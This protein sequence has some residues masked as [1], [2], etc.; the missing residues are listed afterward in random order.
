[1]NSCRGSLALVL[2]ALSAPAAA[3]A[4]KPASCPDLTGAERLVL[5]LGEGLDRS[6]ARLRLYER[7]GK[8][9]KA[10][11]RAKPA[12]LG[13]DGM[14]WAWNAAAY[15]GG[16]SLK[17]EG[18]RRTP[19]GFFPI[20]QPF[21]FSSGPAGYVRLAP[22]ESYCVDDPASAHYNTVLRKAAAGGASGEDMGTIALYRQGLFVD[23]PTNAR[24]KGGSCIFLHTWRTRTS[25]TAGCVALAE[26]DVRQ[27]QQWT[28]GRKALIAILP[29]SAWKTLSR[30][31][32]GI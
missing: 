11:G 19:A 24:A 23:Y 16:S 20:G 26:K 17:A 5:V 9:W 13:I 27:V 22:G 7:S 8:G 6:G 1:M 14:A 4:H 12:M 25:S 30:C 10:G 3:R 18:D 28:A 2:L 32:P 15:A 31:F 29:Q 21:G